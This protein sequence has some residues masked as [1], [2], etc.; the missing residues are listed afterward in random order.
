VEVSPAEA[1]K[2]VV[3]NGQASKEQVKRMVSEILSLES[4]EA[5][6]DATDAL[7]LALTQVRRMELDRNLARAGRPG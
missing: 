5:P 3:G 4:I 1:K 6:L 7:A 2:A